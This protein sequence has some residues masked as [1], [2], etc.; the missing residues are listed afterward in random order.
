MYSKANVFPSYKYDQPLI[1]PVHLS[2]KNSRVIAGRRKDSTWTGAVKV[3]MT[4][5]RFTNPMAELNTSLVQF[6]LQPSARL[7]DIVNI[8]RVGVSNKSQRE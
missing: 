8:F 6:H 3:A 7:F 2:T 5:Q 1:G 4:S